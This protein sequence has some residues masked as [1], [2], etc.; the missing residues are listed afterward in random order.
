MQSFS[1][2][3]KKIRI[4]KCAVGKKRLGNTGVHT[5]CA[6]RGAPSR[7][8][9]HKPKPSLFGLRSAFGAFGLKLLALGH[10][11]EDQPH[12]AGAFGSCL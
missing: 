8:T 1:V 10:N 2:P 7:A 9:C 12:E 3:R 6:R 5:V 4:G 11:C